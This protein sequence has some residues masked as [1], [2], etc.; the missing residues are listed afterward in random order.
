MILAVCL[1]LISIRGIQAAEKIDLKLNLTP[2]TH[3]VCTMENNQSVTQTVDG[4]DHSMTQEMT[5]R[6]NYDVIGK[7]SDGNFDIKL[8]YSG[9]K[10]KQS[11]EE[12][13]VEYDSDNPPAYL[14]PS[15]KSSEAM[16]GSEI[17]LKIS[18]AGKTIAIDGADSLVARMIT[19]L[20]LPN[21]PRNDAFIKDL[22]DKFGAK[23]LTQSM[24][25]ITS[26]IPNKPVRV[27]DSWK[28]ETM[29]N[30]GF[31]MKIVSEYSLVSVGDSVALVRDSSNV[32]TN[33][34]DN[35]VKAGELTMAYDISGTQIGTIE[36]D[37][38]TGLPLR[39]Q[40]DLN[41]TGSVTVSG[42]KDK[43][44]QTWPQKISGTVVV[45][46]EKVE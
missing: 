25:Q 14:D 30:F 45:T 26:Y 40:I 34:D 23:A 10:S 31:P 32:I 17:R 38:A 3:Y 42:M 13:T 27:A 37:K 5:I 9:I 21:S 22:S 11:M 33:P 19:A 24:D 41:S 2:G 29:M 4:F 35:K 7:D 1:V 6:W 20:A 12:R 39:S 46:F 8:T 18:P 44:P 15:M 16:L 43:E 36:I 28:S